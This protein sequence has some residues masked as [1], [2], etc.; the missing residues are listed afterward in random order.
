MILYIDLSELR[1]L[2][3]WEIVRSHKADQQTRTIGQ[4]RRT[5]PPCGCHGTPVEHR[6]STWKAGRPREPRIGAASADRVH[7]A[8]LY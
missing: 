5:A 8:A 6:D 2:P 1:Q 4:A 3:D 7:T